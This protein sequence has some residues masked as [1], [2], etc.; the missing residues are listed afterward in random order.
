[1]RQTV[2]YLGPQHKHVD[3]IVDAGFAFRVCPDFEIRR[4]EFMKDILAEHGRLF[5]PAPFDDRYERKP[6]G[7]R[8][9]DQAA[10]L[11]CSSGLI[12]CEGIMIV[13]LANGNMFPMPHAWC[14]T[15]IGTVVDP[16]A[17]KYQDH[18]RIKYFGIPFKLPYVL[19]WKKTYGFHGMLDGV[20]SLGDSVGVYVDPPAVWKRELDV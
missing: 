2:E 20:P 8:C 9:Y 14:C 7:G 18:R 11:A 16:T 17:H 19:R 1:M 5:F 6:I 4:F 12:Y 13:K 10:E 15:P 3:L